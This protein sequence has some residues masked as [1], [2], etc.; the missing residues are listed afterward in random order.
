MRD[1]LKVNCTMSRIVISIVALIMTVHFDSV[2]ARYSATW[3]AE[4]VRLNWSRLPDIPD[5]IGLA[6]PIVG[7]HNDQLVVGGGA[8]FAKP[9]WESEKQW[10]ARMYVL[11]LKQTST[12]WKVATSLT[13]PLAYSA[14]ISTPRGI[15]V[16][17]GNDAKTT[18]RSCLLL[19]ADAHGTLNYTAMPDFPQPL[20]YAQGCFCEGKLFVATGQTDASLTSATDKVWSLDLNKWLSGNSENGHADKRPNESWVEVTNCPGGPRAHASVATVHHQGKPCVLIAGGRKQVGETTVFLND[21]WLWSINSSRWARLADMPVLNAA[22]GVG[23]LPNN[24][25][26][27][28]SGDSGELFTKTDA[29]RDQHPGFAKRTWLFDIEQNQWSKGP[30]SPMNQVT[31]TPVQYGSS[32]IIAS[33]EIRPRVRTPNVWVVSQR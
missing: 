32:I 22:G 11:D 6:G 21:C 26:I 16:V 1:L 27:S 28:L 12:G 3:G 24:I 2:S 19:M 13:Q 29:L 20:V 9:V 33:G 17:G 25:L 31:T 4:P 15:V 7:I 10:H 23:L 8:N 18:S 5:S 14:C 30:E